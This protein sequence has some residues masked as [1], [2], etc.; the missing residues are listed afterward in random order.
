MFEIK[1]NYWGIAAL[2]LLLIIQLFLYFIIRENIKIKYLKVNL[3]CKIKPL[4]VVRNT[5]KKEFNKDFYL[6]SKKNYF[7]KN[8]NFKKATLIIDTNS[9]DDSIFSTVNLL[10]L[11]KT[12]N[13]KFIKK[14]TLIFI[15]KIVFVSLI[16]IIFCFITLNLWIIA[17][18]IIILLLI[19]IF[20]EFLLT[21]KSEK[22]NYILLKNYF[23]ENFYDQNLK[24]ILKYA[25]YKRFYLFEKYLFFYVQIIKDLVIL[26]KNWGNNE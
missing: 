11:N 22:Q 9:I 5:L 12:I 10:Y 20:I 15:W 13:S 26:F 19:V 7:S 23:I 18:A 24:L 14:E 1:F 6:N 8:I 4:S 21:Y 2:V 25:K 17:M 16:T 3:N